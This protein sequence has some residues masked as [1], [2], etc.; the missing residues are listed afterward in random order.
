MLTLRMGAQR[1]PLADQAKK[2]G[3]PLAGNFGDPNTQLAVLSE[4]IKNVQDNLTRI[5]TEQLPKLGDRITG[6]ESKMTVWDT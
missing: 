5:E 1:T 2:T 4:R 3:V 6:I